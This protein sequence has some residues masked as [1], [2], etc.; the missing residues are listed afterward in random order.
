[1][2]G[3]I[4]YLTTNPEVQELVQLQSTSLATEV[5]EEVRERSV[6]ADTF[7]EGIARSLLRR[8]PRAFLPEPPPEVRSAAVHIHKSKTP[9]AGAPRLGSGPATGADSGKSGRDER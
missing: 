2:D 7:L 1:V 9:P 6:S 8:V 4:D 5:V 3:Y